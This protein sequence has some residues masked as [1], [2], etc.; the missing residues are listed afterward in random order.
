MNA[1][2]Q[3]AQLRAKRAN[4]PLLGIFD[5]PLH[6][7]GLYHSGP[8]VRLL[9]KPTLMARQHDRARA[10]RAILRKA[11]KFAYLVDF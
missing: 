5:F 11:R 9:H 2:A 10:E 6:L 3:R 7:R 1:R 4:L 8:K